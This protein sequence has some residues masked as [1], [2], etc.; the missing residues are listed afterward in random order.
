MDWVSRHGGLA[1][2]LALLLKIVDTILQQKK[3]QFVM[4][5]V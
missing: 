3:E 1:G 4:S 2:W 5:K